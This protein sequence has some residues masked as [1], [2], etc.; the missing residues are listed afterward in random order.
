MDK[1]SVKCEI[2]VTTE[3]SFEDSQGMVTL[4][5]VRFNLDSK[6]SLEHVAWQVADFSE[7]RGMKRAVKSGIRG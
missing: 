2:Q 4:R 3:V 5:R 1:I 6:V 7:D